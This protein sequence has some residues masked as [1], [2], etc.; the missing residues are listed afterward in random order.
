[1]LKHSILAL[2]AVMCIALT[3]ATARAA[4]RAIEDFFGAYIGRSISV[5]GEG[6]TRRD[7]NVVIKP[8]S[9][10]FTVEWTTITHKTGGKVKSKS[11][12]VNFFKSK[13]PGIFGS[14]MRNNVFGAAV[15]L[16][17]LEG[18]PYFWAG[19]NGD[20]LTVHALMITDNGGYELQVYVRTLTKNGMALRFSRLLDGQQLKLITGTLTKIDK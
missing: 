9:K 11:Y 12:S 18:D 19:V 2:I 8:Y 7:L 1:M 5:K 17:P 13:R 16:D 6:L 20:T 14:A 4:D 15:P 3:T 10:G